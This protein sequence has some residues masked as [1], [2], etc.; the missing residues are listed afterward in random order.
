[1]SNT[2]GNNENKTPNPG[3]KDALKAEN[4]ALKAELEA[5]KAQ[6]EKDAEAAK[7]ELEELKAK[8]AE[9]NT[10]VAVPDAPVV[11]EEERVELFIPRGS[12]GED[13]NEIIGL[14]GVL[15]LFPK[16]KTSLVPAAVAAE[17]HRA[18]RAKAIFDEGVSQRL[19]AAN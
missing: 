19:E 14:N 12:T 16:G 4:E 5:A 15:Y 9:G 1:M 18:Q 17:Y 8:M 13:P 11:P 2:T 7:A 10:T 6:A 3:T